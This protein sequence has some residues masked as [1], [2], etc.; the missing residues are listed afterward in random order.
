MD[1]LLEEMARAGATAAPGE[2]TS[3]A[4]AEKAPQPGAPGQVAVRSNARSGAKQ[5]R[6]GN[7]SAVKGCECELC[8]AERAKW[9]DKG[10]R[11]RQSN[12]QSGSAAPVPGQQQPPVQSVASDVPPPSD[13]LPPVLWRAEHLRPLVSECVPVVEALDLRSLKALASDVS[14]EARALVEEQGGWHPVSKKAL[15]HSLPECVAKWLNAAGVSAEHKEEITL[16]GAL[17]A[18]L[19]AS[20]SLRNDLREMA[21]EKRALQKQTKELNAPPPTNQN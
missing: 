5:Q 16:A 20:L 2:A 17:I 19:Y 4:S 9:R 7:G 13:A 18:I 21:A 3:Q 14:P 11:A 6:H 1:P 15:V 10:K 8:T 12:P